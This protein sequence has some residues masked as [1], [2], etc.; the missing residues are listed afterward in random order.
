M[1]DVDKVRGDFPI[2]AREVN[3]HRL[4]Y[5]DNAATTQKPKVVIDAIVDFYENHNA[6]VARGVHKLAEEATGMYEDARAKVAE[7]IGAKPAEIVF[8]RNSTEALN[9]VAFSWGFS[10][11]KRGD[12]VV[13]SVLEHHSNILPWRMLE[14]KGVEIRYVDVDGEVRIDLEDLEKKLDSD[15]KLVAVSAKSNAVGTLQPIKEIVDLVKRKTKA[16]IVLDGSHSV[17]HMPVDVGKLGVDFLAFSGHKMLAPM[18]SGVLWAKKELLE[19]MQPFL[20]GGDMISHVSLT[21]ESWN[22]VPHKFEAGT[23]NV[24]AAVG[25]AAG[26][27]YLQKIGMDN[28]YR[29]E[30]ELTEYALAKFEELNKDRKVVEVYGPKEAGQRAGV[31][32][33]NVLGIH[34][35]DVAQI[36]DS[37][38]IAVRSGQHCTGPLMEKLEIPASVRASFYFY[39][40]REEI[41][42]L[43][44]KIPAVLKV[45]R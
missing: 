9:L 45:F 36:L 42:Y 1:F 27:H 8:V 28:I 11:L 18:G 29:Y 20:R 19:N 10:Q 6:N 41:D 39:N 13:S 23:P 5:L 25:M 43:V 30:T 12:V 37:F 3:G 26:I 7:F 40:T 34:A 4:V 14:D 32:S 31:V 33:F 44:D 17:P 24:E 16:K 15:V 21:N 2:L 35:H 38:G 22:E